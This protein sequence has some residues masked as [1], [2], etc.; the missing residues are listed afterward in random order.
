MDPKMVQKKEGMG[1]LRSGV[2]NVA[3]PQ[4]NPD[5]FDQHA[6]VLFA[7][8]DPTRISDFFF[9]PNCLHQAKTRR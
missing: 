7:G 1:S 8:L 4:M 3:S 2:S 5:Q 9:V 6:A